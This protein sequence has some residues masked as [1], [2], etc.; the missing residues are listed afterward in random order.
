MSLI[1]EVLRA[2]VDA[3]SG[4]LEEDAVLALVDLLEPC[5]EPS[6]DAGSSP[7]WERRRKEIV[8]AIGHLRA[9]AAHLQVSTDIERGRS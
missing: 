1:K 6:E 2:F 5:A 9:A 8:A 3:K 4:C 7:K